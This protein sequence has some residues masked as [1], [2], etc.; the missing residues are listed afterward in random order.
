MRIGRRT[1]LSATCL[2]WKR[3]LRL[4]IL[5]SGVFRG[6]DT[7]QSLAGSGPFRDTVAQAP[8]K[9]PPGIGGAAVAARLTPSNF[10][11]GE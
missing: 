3:H 4:P 6:A 1:W 9:Q 2:G 5:P 10:A 7:C 11:P 8:H